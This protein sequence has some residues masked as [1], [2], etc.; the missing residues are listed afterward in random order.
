MYVLYFK[1]KTYIQLRWNEFL[2]AN[3]ECEVKKKPQAK[4][5]A[6][7]IFIGTFHNIV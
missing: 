5:V 2:L 4:K 1:V 7:V 3:G 6:V